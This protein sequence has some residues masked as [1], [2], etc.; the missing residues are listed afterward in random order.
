MRESRR[1]AGVLLWWGLLGVFLAILVPVGFSAAR[2]LAA[3]GQSGILLTPEEGGFRVRA[4]GTASAVGLRPDDILLLVDGG[5]ARTL[6]DPVRA[7]EG[8]ER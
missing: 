3:T 8:G 4:P 6:P 2:K 7:P 5:E 1:R